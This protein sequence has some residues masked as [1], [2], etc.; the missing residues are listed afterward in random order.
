MFKTNS[1]HASVKFGLFELFF[2][3]CHYW[4]LGKQNAGI[5]RLANFCG[6]YFMIKLYIFLVLLLVK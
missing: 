1:V 4:N 5:L 2:K 6:S 3:T